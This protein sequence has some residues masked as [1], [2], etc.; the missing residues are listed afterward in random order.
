MEFKLLACGLE[1]RPYRIN[2][3]KLE[4]HALYIVPAIALST[5]EVECQDHRSLV[6]CTDLHSLSD[7]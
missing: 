6:I 3:L 4:L 7:L 5:A 2:K 1:F